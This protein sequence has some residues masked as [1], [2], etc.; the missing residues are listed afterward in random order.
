MARRYDLVRSPLAQALIATL[1]FLC[2]AAAQ[3]APLLY[4]D[5]GTY[6]TVGE[7]V[8]RA[9]HL[10]PD[11][12]ADAPAVAPGPATDTTAADPRLP[13]TIAAAR[14]AFYGL[15]LYA[16]VTLGT[17]WLVIAVQA[18]LG[19]W[20]V[21][22]AFCQL[23]DP[24]LALP[25]LALLV[26]VTAMPSFAMLLMPDFAAPLAVLSAMLLLWRWPALGP[27]ARIALAAVLLGACL[28]HSTHKLVV[29]A[30]LLATLPLLWLMPRLHRPA[31]AG[32]LWVFGVVA[33]SIAGSALYPVA[34]RVATGNAIYSPPF[35][36][37]RA[38]TDGT[39]R[40]YLD[41]IC[42]AEPDRFAMC[43]FRAY[44][45]ATPNDF[46][47]SGDNVFQRA[48][49]DTR[50][51]LAREDSR[52]YLA[53][54]LDAPLATLAN[55]ATHTAELLVSVGPGQVYR[56]QPELIAAETD[57]VA[58]LAPG[59]LRCQRTPP[60]CA[61]LVAPRAAD[62]I[63]AGGVIIALVAIAA[64]LLRRSV[65]PRRWG[66]LL[67]FVA[68]ALLANAAICGTFSISTPRYQ[69]RLAWLIPL[70][71]MLMAASA[72]AARR[73]MR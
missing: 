30:A 65:D 31:R 66:P 33:L 70:L 15:P 59:H 55:A 10:A 64:M 19:F 13:Y 62:A 60:A 57:L 24:R 38:F 22:F 43:H 5:A 49:Y 46:L 47:W 26:L 29:L 7:R 35:L 34:V 28:L 68:L 11:A 2:F 45:P 54:A 58:T 50:V 39:G 37:A 52:F 41:R 48:D 8:A 56:E 9:L 67:L 36:T 1:F 53:S 20:L 71:A 6:H 73:T 17:S 16:L 4:Y 51:R 63:A 18:L 25:A 12:A 32:V 23:A 27:I 14:P 42:P 40:A 21:A 44:R 3:K 69:A 61:P 72:S